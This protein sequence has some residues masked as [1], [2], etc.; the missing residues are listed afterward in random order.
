M[1]ET[2][3]AANKLR[4]AYDGGNSPRAS[5]INRSGLPKGT[6]APHF[7]LPSLDGTEVSHT[8]L[9]NGPTLLVFSDPECV[10]CNELAPKLE[11]LHRRRSDLQVLMISRRDLELTRKKVAELG[12]TFQ[13]CVQRNWEVSLKYGTFAT[14]SGYL[15]DKRGIISSGV[16]IGAE[17]ILALIDGSTQMRE[18]VE[19]RVATLKREYDVGQLQLLDQERRL[20]SLRETMLRIGGAMQVLQELLSPDPGL[21]IRRGGTPVGDLAE[22]ATKSEP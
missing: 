9:L 4:R 14:P 16:A 5:R 21:Q 10:P 1:T 7:L 18:R 13:V 19:E 3:L 2:A 6:A 15:I 22:V 8:V 11:H 17:S 12:I 20:T